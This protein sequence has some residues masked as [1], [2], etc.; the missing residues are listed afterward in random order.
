MAVLKKGTASSSVSDIAKELVVSATS[1]LWTTVD[2]WS[3]LFYFLRGGKLKTCP[4]FIREVRKFPPP[5]FHRPPP[6]ICSCPSY[7]CLSV[8]L[9]H[10]AGTLSRTVRRMSAR[11]SK[12]VP[13]R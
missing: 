13:W 7:L 6:P 12:C 4:Y 11:W 5:S 2:Y 9:T 8:S 3:S 10:L 1:V